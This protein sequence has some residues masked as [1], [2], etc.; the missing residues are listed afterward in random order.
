MSELTKNQLKT[1]NTNSFPN[2]NTGYITPSILRDFNVNMIDSLVDEVSYNVDSASFNQ[3]ITALDPS[4]SAAAI[5]ALEIATASLNTYTASN[6]AK[7]NTLGGQTGSFITEAETG[8]FIQASQTSS[9]SVLSSSY[10]ITASYAANATIDTSSF[11][12]TNVNNSF[13]GTQTFNNV[14]VSGTASVAFLD[15]TYQSSSIIYSSGSNQLGDASNDIQ[16]LFGQVD[17]KNNLASTGSISASQGFFG[18]LEGTASYATQALTASY[19][20]N[21]NVNTGSFATTG[22]NVFVGNQTIT[23]SVTISGS[24]TSKIPTAGNESQTNLIDFAPFVGANGTTYTSANVSLQDYASSNIDQNF[25]V[26]YANADFQKYTALTVG[27]T[28]GG[29]KA[30]F[31]INT[32]TGYDFDEI[33]ITDNGNGTSTSLIKADTN[34]ILGN[35]SLTGSLNVSNGDILNIGSGTTINPL[36]YLTESVSGHANIIKGWG[37]TP[38]AGGAGATQANYTG[39]LRITGSNN[40]V[41]L[42]QIRA[43]DVGGGVDQT[44]YISGSDNIIAG[45]QAGIYLNTGSQLYPKVNNNQLSNNSAILM[46]FTTSSLSGGHPIIQNNNL[47]GGTITFNHNSG[48]LAAANANIINGGA[49]TS[50]QNFVTNTRPAVSTNI[51][52]GN[53]ATI[54]HISSSVSFQSNIANSGVTINNHL[55]SSG[56]S[57]NGLSFTNNTILG[58][59]SNTGLAVFVSGSQASNANRLFIDNLIGGRNNVVSSSFVSS[60]A[61]SLIGNIIYGQNLRVNGNS[62]V[63]STSGGSAFFG[64]YNDTGSLSNSNDIVFAIGTG[65]SGNRR[66]GFWI[67]SGSNTNISGTLDVIGNT[68]FTGSVDV[69]GSTLSLNNNGGLALKV[70]SGSVEVTSP[71]GTGYFYSNLPITSSNLRIN[72]TGLLGDLIVSGVFSGNSSLQVYG[73]SSFTGSVFTSASVS[74]V[75]N[76]LTISSDTASL[77]FSKG[78]FFTIQLVS[79]SSTHI[80]PTNVVAGQTVNIRVNTTGS[81]AVTFQSTVKQVSG[82][83]YTPT[84][85]TGVDVLTMVTFDTSNVYLANVK[86]LV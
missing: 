23:G 82:S 53:T 27:P 42:P 5:L 24:F 18:N 55:S 70:Y 1:D 51:V 86:N 62:A 44:G 10:A 81:G 13:N 48:S 59:S 11:A 50:T 77:D 31:S 40:T 73:N 68:S 26:E 75:V 35:V 56:L 61:S 30:Q 37:E 46:N 45:N 76:P 79:G 72:G 58:G 25:V 6:D 60:S 39:S 20:L 65:T 38:A 15:V 63:S 14:V 57:N 71:Q 78:N 33:S 47:F 74:G 2:N 41:A 66:T 16:T 19:A 8:S 69:T 67:D 80:N 17:V 22:S 32:G 34:K 3:R 83:A 54:N 64:R 52:I 85:A 49:I 21:T 4:G 9:M 36:L 43:T 84:T 29:S 12:K 28:T 7:W